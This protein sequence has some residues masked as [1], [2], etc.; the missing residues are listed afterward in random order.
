MRI[1]ILLLLLLLY[2]YD[3]IVALL[4]YARDY[5]VRIMWMYKI[6]SKV[7]EFSQN[8]I[9]KTIAVTLRVFN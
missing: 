6:K 2:E 4:Q 7:K 1:L 8:K 9:N 3:Y 5:N